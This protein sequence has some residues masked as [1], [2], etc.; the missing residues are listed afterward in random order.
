VAGPDKNLGPQWRRSSDVLVTG[1][2]D[3]DGF[4]LNVAREKDSFGWSTLATLNAG[5]ADVGA[6]TG[7]VC[8]TGSGRYAA[9]VYAPAMAVN[10]PA[11]ITAGAFAAV[12]DTTTGE[13]RQV[14]SHVQLAYFNPSCGPSDRVL[15]TRSIGIDQQ[16]TDLISV[17]A[18]GATATSSRRVNAQL[19]TPMPAPDGDYG[20]A[21]GALVRVD[22]AGR[23]TTVATPGGQPFAVRATSHGAID[24]LTVQRQG[25]EE[26]SVAQRF[27]VG[28]LTRIGDAPRT[29]LDLFSLSG[30]RDV[31][32]GE[33]RGI[34]SGKFAEL[35]SVSSDRNPRAVSGRDTSWFWKC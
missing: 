29:R 33:L 32:V 35:S 14:A 19:T 7:Y 31:L 23:L 12:V 30:G 21:H 3:T 28:K 5:M 1:V 17:D 2:G 9:V 13:A 18:T 10:K 26:R 6:W 15:F 11:L 4:H 22:Q 27:A 25:T 8:V 20:I 16:Q 24:L 34:N